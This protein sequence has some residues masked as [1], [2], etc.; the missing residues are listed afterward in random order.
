MIF[1][2]FVGIKLGFISFHT[3]EFVV[4]RLGRYGNPAGLKKGKFIVRNIG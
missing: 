2:T 1:I 4:L 3:F